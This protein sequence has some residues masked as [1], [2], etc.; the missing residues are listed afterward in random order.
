MHRLLTPADYRRMPWKNGGGVTVEIA[1][2]PA[3]AALDAFDWRVSVADV[4]ADGPFSRFPGVDRIL[5]LLAGTGLHLAGA[6]HDVDLR[7][8]YEPYA[9][10]GDDAVEGRLVDGPVRDFNLMLRRGRVRGGVSVVRT[11]GEQLR[12]A[13]VHLSYAAGGAHEALRPGHP[14]A[15]VAE[16]EALLIVA[17]AD[18]PPAS[19]AVNPLGAGAVALVVALDP[20]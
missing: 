15:I 5:L 12:A 18:E 17:D 2:H 4:A 16:G 6:G 3:Q 14:P 13:R 9:F 20:P 10:S 11:T 19:L 1:A 8:P 7:A